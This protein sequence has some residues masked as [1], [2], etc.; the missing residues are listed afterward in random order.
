MTISKWTA[1]GGLAIALLVGL[2]FGRYA[3][4]AKV[5]EKQVI[6]ETTRDTELTWHAYVGHTET[7][8]AEKTNWKTVTE[9]KPGDVVT[10]TVYVDRDRTEATRTDTA[11]ADGQIKEKLVEKLVYKEKLVESPKPD[12]LFAAKAGLLLD[13]RRPIYG[14]EVG[15]R[16]LGPVFVDVWAQAAGASLDGAAAGVG[17]TVLW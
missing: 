3:T 4:P 9:W 15:R 6:V 12:W 10:Q 1:A 2:L 8:I 17:V 5:V 16:I 13:D 14:G 7:R 11:T